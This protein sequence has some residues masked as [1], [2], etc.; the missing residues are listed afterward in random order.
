LLLSGYSKSAE[1]T[2]DVM[3]KDPKPTNIKP[4]RFSRI[5]T[6][7]SMKKR[8]EKKKKKRKKEA[9]K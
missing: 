3:K 5:W 8:K 7:Q 4:G 1:G 2:A 9:N 6:K